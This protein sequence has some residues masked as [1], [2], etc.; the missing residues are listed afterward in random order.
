VDSDITRSRENRHE[1]LR[2]LAEVANLMLDA[3]MILIV[4]AQELTQEELDLI[5]TT[6]DPGRI[7]T[8]WVGDRGTS[9]LT[10]DLSLSELEGDE[11]NVERIRTLLLQKGVLF[12]PW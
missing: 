7:E 3:G 2:R 4:S 6:V 8:M 5:K 12:Q 1:H 10:A 11:Q 9:D